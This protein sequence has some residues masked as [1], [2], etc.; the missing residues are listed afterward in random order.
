MINYQSR[1]RV[2][3]LRVYDIYIPELN[4][5]VKF[6]VLPP[7]EIKKIMDD[8]SDY[9]PS[10]HMRTVV[11]NFVFNMRHEI[12]DALKLLSEDAGEMAIEAL[13]NG[14]VMLNPGL[15]ID[16]WVRIAY[17]GV[18]PMPS[19]KLEKKLT[20][21]DPSEIPPDLME[22][23]NKAFNAKTN[24]TKKPP[25]I[26]KAKINNLA[27]HLKTK[28]IGQDEAVETVANALK[29]S[30]TGMNDEGRPLGV[31][32]LAGSSGT[33]KTL[34]AKELHTYLFGK[35]YD[36]V[37]IDCGEFQQKHENQKLI[38]SPPGYIGHEDGGMLTS[39]MREQ[40][41]TV[42]L[43]DEVEKA[44]PDIWNTFLRVFD[45]GLLTDNKGK[46]V[47]F[48]NSVII[49]TTNLGNDKVVESLTGKGT[50]F[51]ARINIDLSSKEIPKREVV[52]KIANEAIRKSFKP[53]FLNR[54]DKVIVF[55]HLSYEDYL[56]IARLEID[57]VDKKLMKKGFILNSDDTVL[58]GLVD[59]GVNTIFGAR[60]MSRVRREEIE[61][62]IAGLIMD[63]TFK[64]GT[65]F[66]ISY[67]NTIFKI[68]ILGN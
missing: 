61:D 43:L 53:E 60:G 38:G 55:N 50:G 31:F 17:S 51:S 24:D 57:I 2:S 5:Y 40:P 67:F 12:V 62:K 1:K 23:A 11:E 63:N 56:E 45:E 6:K 32:L 54:I 10:E 41:Q 27:K 25:K 37:R 19:N 34:L 66:E 36:L 15:D 4:R 3:G 26:T 42:V 22:K 64:R 7:E 29:R 39:K 33:G 30:M 68:N 8:I 18:K 49:M 46:E 21:L 20:K 16:S 14:C 13:F 47:S 58:E 44:H 48:R 35:E 9:D 65:I 59:K 52:E 28:I